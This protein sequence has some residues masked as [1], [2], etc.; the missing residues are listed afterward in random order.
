MGMRDVI[1]HH[2]FD[3]DHETVY[4]VCKERI[5]AM[6]EAV[7]RILKDITAEEH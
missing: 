1:A 4:V 2:Y 3:I 6:K 7:E 5:P